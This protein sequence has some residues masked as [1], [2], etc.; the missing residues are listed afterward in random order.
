MNHEET[1]WAGLRFE[2]FF[3]HKLSDIKLNKNGCI[4]VKSILLYQTVPHIQPLWIPTLFCTKISQRK[5]IYFL[6]VQ[7]ISYF[8]FNCTI[9]VSFCHMTIETAEARQIGLKQQ[10]QDRLGC[11][12]NTICCWFSTIL[13]HTPLLPLKSMQLAVLFT[14]ISPLLYWCKNNI[15]KTHSNNSNEKI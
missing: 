1:Y 10:K 4:L 15:E 11:L 5:M 13:N 9:S 6:C 7:S 3:P 8:C 2:R 14:Y 12:L